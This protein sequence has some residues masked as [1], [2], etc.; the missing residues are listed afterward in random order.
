MEL[1]DHGERTIGEHRGG[2]LSLRARHH[3][4]AVDLAGCGVVRVLPG[5]DRLLRL[6][7]IGVNALLHLDHELV[8]RGR[9][10]DVL[11][12]QG[13]GVRQDPLRHVAIDG[14]GDGPHETHHRSGGLAGARVSGLRGAPCA[15]IAGVHRRCLTG[16]DSRELLLR[17][18]GLLLRHALE[19]R[20]RGP[21]DEVLRLLETGKI[22]D[23]LWLPSPLE[24]IEVPIREIINWEKTRKAL[25]SI[26][27]TP[28]QAVMHHPVHTVAPETEIEDAAS[29]MLKHHIARL[30]VMEEGRLVGIVTRRDIVEGI[31][32]GSEP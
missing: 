13:G 5:D 8:G 15:G 26:G 20:L 27:D 11:P 29:L 3:R 7:R 18:V 28:V 25:S 17:L 12:A 1:D 24:I 6:R 9:L 4:L 23:D 22:S 32:G 21:V 19:D 31:A 2:V 16:I 10:R 14:V 30:P